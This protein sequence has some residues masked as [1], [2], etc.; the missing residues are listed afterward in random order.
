MLNEME[1][2]DSV[3]PLPVIAATLPSP[4]HR[5]GLGQ[6]GASEMNIRGCEAWLSGNSFAMCFS[7]AR[8]HRPTGK[9]S[10]AR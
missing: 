6:S 3:E 5:T 9:V 8:L 10:S 2:Y 7:G 4:G 1:G